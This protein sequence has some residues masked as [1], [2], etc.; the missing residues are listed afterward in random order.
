MRV[1]VCVCM[2]VCACVRVRVRVCVRVRARARAR[3]FFVRRRIITLPL[4]LVQGV[5]AGLDP[6]FTGT[7]TPKHYNR[8]PVIHSPGTVILRPSEVERGGLNKWMHK[9]Q[10]DGS[11]TKR[12]VCC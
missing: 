4:T 8:F 1:C 2:C 3:A 10:G 12:W 7:P 5:V 9:L 11:A 6:K